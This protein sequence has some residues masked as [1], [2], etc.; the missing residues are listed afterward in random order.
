MNTNYTFG[1]GKFRWTINDSYIERGVPG[2]LV[3]IREQLDWIKRQIEYCT[4]AEKFK[5]RYDLKKS[6]IYEI[7]FGLNVNTEF[8]NRHY[9]VVIKDSSEYNPQVLVCPLK[10]NHKGPH[11]R[12]DVDIGYVDDLNSGHTTIAVINQIRP[13]DKLRIYTQHRIGYD[14]GLALAEAENEM[15]ID[16]IPRLNDKQMELILNAYC[17]YL[18]GDDNDKK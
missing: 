1:E 4:F 3:G 5:L 7:D 15:L 14:D 16:R 9:G 17:N 12:S 18:F 6:E 2:R 13:I 8:S 10:T 11:P